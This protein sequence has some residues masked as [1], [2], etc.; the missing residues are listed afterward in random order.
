MM[1]SDDWPTHSEELG[2][3]T[4]AVVAKWSAVYEKSGI[5]KREFYILISGLYDATSGIIPKADGDVI[6]AIHEELR[7]A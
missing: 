4:L 1:Q 3:K 5:T 2:R 7:R 6:A